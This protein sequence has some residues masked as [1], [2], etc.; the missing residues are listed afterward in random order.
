[1]KL[2][3][4]T[5]NNI[6]KSYWD[7]AKNFFHFGGWSSHFSS[8]IIYILFWTEKDWISGFQNFKKAVFFRKNLIHSAVIAVSAVDSGKN[9]SFLR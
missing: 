4:H 8:K 7:G 3:L 5:E 2:F 1:M 6:A 9:C